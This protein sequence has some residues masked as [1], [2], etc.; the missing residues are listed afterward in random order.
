LEPAGIQLEYVVAKL[1]DV[2]EKQVDVEV[3][4][5]D[6]QMHL[7]ADEGEAGAEFAQ[8]VHDPVGQ[9]LLQIPFGDFT[10][11]AEEFEVVRVFRRLLCQL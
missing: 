7:P 2:E 8:G 10:G 1:F 5:P 9:L 4:S 3:V 6:L 11:Q